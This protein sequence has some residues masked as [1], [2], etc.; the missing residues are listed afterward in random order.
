MKDT[1]F[2]TTEAFLNMIGQYLNEEDKLKFK[3]ELKNGNAL[4]LGGLNSKSPERRHAAKILQILLEKVLGETE[5]LDL[6]PAYALKDIFE[7]RVCTESIAFAY[8]KGIMP[9]EDSVFGVKEKIT[10]EEAEELIGRCFDPSKR[11]KPVILKETVIP[12]IIDKEKFG[13]LMS[14]KSM[15]VV[16]IRPEYRM[17]SSGL[18]KNAEYVNIPLHILIKNPYV[19]NMYH[20]DSLYRPTVLTGDDENAVAAAKCLINAGYRTV[21]VWLSREDQE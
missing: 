16:D 19:L 4:I 12:G 1:G 18:K 9:A 8:V 15:V 7:C 21:Y 5:T 17:L 13:S 14:D 3:E 6:S 20:S 11:I 10:E 2:F